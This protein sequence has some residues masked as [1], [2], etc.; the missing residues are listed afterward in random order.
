MIT[1]DL[2]LLTRGNQPMKTTIPEGIGVYWNERPLRAKSH[3]G[4]QLV[5]FKGNMSLKM[6]SWLIELKSRNPLKTSP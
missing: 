5:T 1:P 4:H 2:T 3:Q 6:R